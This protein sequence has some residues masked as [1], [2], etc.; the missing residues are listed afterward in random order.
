MISSLSIYFGRLYLTNEHN[1]NYA[2]QPSGILTDCLMSERRDSGMDS[3][4]H[5]TAQTVICNNK[6]M[7]HCI[8]HTETSHLMCRE[9]QLPSPPSS[10]VRIWYWTMTVSISASCFF[11]LLP[12]VSDHVI[13][14]SNF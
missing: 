11:S 12:F 2:C 7:A 3:K 14:L 1:V 13:L 6:Y 9:E 4:M 8:L 5:Q 10:V